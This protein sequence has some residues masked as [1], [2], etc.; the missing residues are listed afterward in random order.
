VLHGVAHCY[1]GEIK[2]SPQHELAGS[3]GK[4]PVDWAIRVG[5]TIIAI[6]EAKKDDIDQGVGQNVIQLQASR[7]CNPKKRK[8]DSE[9]VMFGVVTTGVSWVIIK[10]VSSG[11]GDGDN[12]D[13]T[14]A[15]NN[16]QVLVSSESPS[17]LPLL[18]RNLDERSLLAA[19]KDL[20]GQLKWI[21]DEQLR[22]EGGLKRRRTL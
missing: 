9:D 5:E 1:G 8:Y 22:S 16:T 17:S 18:G 13:T 7:Q 2:I 20:F 14:T 3:H 6:T 19:L 12:D 15:N 10:V 11:N 4:G 21:F